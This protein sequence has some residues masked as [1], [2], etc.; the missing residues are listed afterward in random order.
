[1]ELVIG[2]GVTGCHRGDCILVT[3]LAAEQLTLLLG[4]PQKLVAIRWLSTWDSKPLSGQVLSFHFG[5]DDNDS[6][7]LWI[8]KRIP[9]GMMALFL[10]T[11]QSLE[12][13]QR[14]SNLEFSS[15]TI[16]HQSFGG[17]DDC[18][19]TDWLA[20]QAHGDIW[21]GE[22]SYP[23]RPIGAF[24]EPSTWLITEYCIHA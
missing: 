22:W 16:W 11:E 14:I 8:M 10:G 9:T 24:L 19:F 7:L 15:S 5:N 2:L 12:K 4:L 3:D 23:T 13:L 20:A 18:S 1:M 6:S 21:P 17:I